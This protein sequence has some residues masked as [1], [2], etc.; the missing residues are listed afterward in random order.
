MK[1]LS[2][3]IVQWGLVSLIVFTPFAFGTVEAWAV[4]IMEW[5]I[6]CLV[7]VAVVGRLWPGR[8]SEFHLRKTGL[9]IPVALFIGYCLMQLVPMPMPWLARLS[10]GAA[11]MYEGASIVKDSPVAVPETLARHDP[12]VNVPTKPMRPISVN[13]GRTRERILLLMSF[14]AVFFLVAHWATEPRRIMFL[15]AAITVTGFA[16]GLF[17]LVQYLTWNG[18]IYWFRRVPSGSAFGPFVNHNH[19]AGYVGMIVPVAVCFGFFFLEARRAAGDE[20]ASDR[21]GRTGLALFAAALIVVALFFSLSRGGILSTCLSCLVLFALVSRRM[22]SRALTWSVAV[23]LVL[24]AVIFISWIGADIVRHKLGTYS[25]IENEA[26]FRLRVMIWKTMIRDAPGFVWVGSGLGTFEESFAQFTPP[27]S[28]RRWDRA[29]NDY[30]QLGW[31]TGLAGAALFLAAA[32]AFLRRYWWP[33]V[34]S[35]RHPMTLFRVGV[36]ISILTI[37]LHSIVDFNLQI[38]SNGFLFAI[39]CGSLVALRDPARELADEAF[40]GQGSKPAMG[41]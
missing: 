38:G 9:E 19:F 32:V 4:A 41:L 40:S 39:L 8:S 37:A 36:C 16:V 33:S 10:P 13:P 26:S 20:A 30:L 24:V 28:A 31:E 14:A 12:L 21:W 29:H 23:A 1:Q 3:R 15:L 17:G 7:I 2:D 11:R 5:G 18:S 34:R 27:G 25:T 35:Q 22:A 6:W